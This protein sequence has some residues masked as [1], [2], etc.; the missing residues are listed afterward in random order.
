MRGILR[1][2]MGAT[3]ILSAGLIVGC[4]GRADDVDLSEAGRLVLRIERPSGGTNATATANISELALV[5]RPLILTADQTLTIDGVRLT[6]TAR[7]TLGLESEYTATIDALSPPDAYR[8]RFNDEDDD[9]EASLTPPEDLANIRPAR[10][11][12][13]STE[14]FTVRWTPAS[15]DQ[16]RIHITVTGLALSVDSN[17]NPILVTH[18]VPFT[19]LRDDGEHRISAA[20][21]DFFQTGEIRVTIARVRTAAP[22]VGFASATVELRVVRELPLVLIE[23]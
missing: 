7:T 6:P 9:F 15:D 16:P 13:V 21:L 22:S 11:S 10:F 1:P 5:N 18:N 3:A 8:L 14:G 20:D 4:P 23:P 2:L 12:E 19:N 17:G